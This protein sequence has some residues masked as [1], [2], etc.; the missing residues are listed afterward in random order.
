ML[1]DAFAGLTNVL[2]EAMQDTRT[3]AQ[4]S[5]DKI[6]NSLQCTCDASVA[7]E[8]Q[9]MKQQ[10]QLALAEAEAERQFLQFRLRMADGEN[11][12]SGTIGD[13]SCYW[14]VSDTTGV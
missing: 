7:Y 9:L 2:W 5:R 1:R 8:R 11:V 10:V 6:R 4:D 12:T 14:C 13:R 3:A